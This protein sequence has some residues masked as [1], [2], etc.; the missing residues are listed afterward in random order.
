MILFVLILNKTIKMSLGKYKI[1]LIC[2]LNYFQ[3]KLMNC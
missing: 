3:N 1:I 2:A